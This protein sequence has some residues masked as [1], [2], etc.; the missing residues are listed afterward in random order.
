MLVIFYFNI[1]HTP[2]KRG[3]YRQ[4]AKTNKVRQ[5]IKTYI[6]RNLVDF[7]HNRHFTL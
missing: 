2:L 5:Q 1:K 4:T 6:G 7:I 3:V